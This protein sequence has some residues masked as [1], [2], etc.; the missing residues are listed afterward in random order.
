[1][2]NDPPT[3]MRMRFGYEQA[4]DVGVTGFERPPDAQQMNW[5]RECADA[6]KKIAALTRT[7]PSLTTLA[8]EVFERLKLHNR[9][10]APQ[11]LA[12]IYWHRPE[13]A[14]PGYWDSTPDWALP[15]QLRKQA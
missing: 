5:H 7:D 9:H 13:L 3:S 6:E 14:P 15:P 1:M 2:A 11:V 8:L 4:R 10:G 12:D